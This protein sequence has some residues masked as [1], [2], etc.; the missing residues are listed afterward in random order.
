MN[1]G[2][3][4]GTRPVVSV[5]LYSLDSFTTFCYNSLVAKRACTVTSPLSRYERGVKHMSN[6]ELLCILLSIASLLLTMYFG[7]R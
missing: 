6:T 1:N 5:L 2:D 4:Q 7:L 3:H